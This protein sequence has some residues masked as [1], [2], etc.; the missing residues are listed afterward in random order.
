MNQAPWHIGPR[1]WNWDVQAE[2]DMLELGPEVMEA[3][4]SEMC[5][6]NPIYDLMMDEEDTLR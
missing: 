2:M 4:D 5:G 3:L 6:W 1:H